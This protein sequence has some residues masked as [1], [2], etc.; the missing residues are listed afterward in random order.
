MLGKIHFECTEGSVP[1]T[2]TRWKHVIVDAPSTGHFL[3]LFSS[4]EALTRVFSAGIILRQSAE[5][6]N[7]V[8]NGNNTEIYLMTLPSELPAK[9]T[10]ELKADL[11]QRGMNARHIVV[12]RIR[13]N[14]EDSRAPQAEGS[15][16]DEF[17]VV[18]K[19]IFTEE[20]EVIADLQSKLSPT[21]RLMKL[22]EIQA[23]PDLSLVQLSDEIE[24]ALI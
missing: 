15:T 2:S 4:I 13:P 6:F 21:D 24:K 5:I 18:E 12:N 19:E 7:F 3:A 14:F 1:E 11:K 23:E 17:L 8:K 10:L 16:W 20:Q 9:E 22:A